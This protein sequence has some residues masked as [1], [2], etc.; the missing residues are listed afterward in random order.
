MKITLIFV[1]YFRNIRT[2]QFFTCMTILLIYVLDTLQ[3][4]IYSC[5]ENFNGIE[6]VRAHLSFKY[7]RTFKSTI[8]YKYFSLQISVLIEL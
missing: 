7:I 1:I 6:T 3:L 5:T 2:M 8:F 4:H